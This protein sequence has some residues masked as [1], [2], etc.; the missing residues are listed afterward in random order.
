MSR[1]HACLTATALMFAFAGP[2]AAQRTLVFDAATVPQSGSVAITVAEGLPQAGSFQAIDTAT[3]GAL[4]RAATAAGF[5]GKAGSRLDLSGF[6][7]FDRL[8][9]L[10]LGTQA[11]DQR[12]LEDI[13]GN[14]AQVAAKSRSPRFELVWDGQQADAPSWLAFGAELG[15]YRFDKYKTVGASDDNAADATGKGEL[16]IRSGVGAAAGTAYAADWQP[17]AGA[18]RFARDLVTEPANALWPE[19]FVARTR[20]AARGL[21]DLHIEV[22]DVPAMEKLGMGSLLAVGQGSV[23]PPRLMLISYNGGKPGDAP[24]A[25]VGKGITF[26]SGGISLKPGTNMWRMKYDMTGAASATATVLGLAGRKAPVNAIAVAALAENMP[27]GSAARPGD[28]IRTGSG[29]TYEII[30]TDAEGRMVLVDALWYLQ[31]QHAPKVIIDIAT[32]TGAIVTALG[33]DY[34]GLFTRDDA[35]ATQLASAGERSGEAVWRMPLREDYGKGLRSPIA[36]L[37]NGG[38]TPG[39]GAAAYF[40][41]EWVDKTIPWAHLDIAGMAWNEGSG[42]PTSPEGATAYGVRLLDRYVRDHHE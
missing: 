4:R 11:P 24:I 28:V 29:K 20:E 19:A 41:G 2:A 42:K 39:S 9:V 18:V 14:V 10:G 35:L 33:S 38:G 34:A 22:L 6:A 7:G 5:S 37:R 16:V 1:L 12:S 30:S 26:D 31:R 36:D 17:V 25:F 3:Q 32:L 27:S 15:Q 23:R 13:G 8:L 40:I 21:P